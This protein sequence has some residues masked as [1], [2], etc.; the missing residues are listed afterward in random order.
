MYLP[1]IWATFEGWGDVSHMPVPVVLLGENTFLNTPRTPSPWWVRTKGFVDDNATTPLMSHSFA[2]KLNLILEPL[3]D[4]MKG[5][6]IKLGTRPGFGWNQLSN[7]PHRAQYHG[8]GKAAVKVDFS[9]DPT[10]LRCAV[11]TFVIF[12]DNILPRGSSVGFV[13][14]GAFTRQSPAWVK[15]ALMNDEISQSF[16]KRL[17]APSHCELPRTC[18]R[19][20]SSAAEVPERRR[21]PARDL[22][23]P[24]KHVLGG[25]SATP[26]ESGHTRSAEQPT[27]SPDA[28]RDRMRDEDCWLT[29]FA[30]A[31][32]NFEW[33]VCPQGLASSPAVAQRLF[34]NVPQSLPRVNERNLPTRDSVKTRRVFRENITDPTSEIVG[35]RIAVSFT[36]GQFVTRRGR[37]APTEVLACI[38]GKFDYNLISMDWICEHGVAAWFSEHCPPAPAKY[39]EDIRFPN[40]EP[41]FGEKLELNGAVTLMVSIAGYAPRGVTFFVF[42]D[43]CHHTERMIINRREFYDYDALHEDYKREEL[44]PG[45][46]TK[47]LRWPDELMPTARASSILALARI[48]KAVDKAAHVAAPCG[49]ADEGDNP[50][51]PWYQRRDGPAIRQD[52]PTGSPEGGIRARIDLD[53]DSGNAPRSTS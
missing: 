6:I 38:S 40:E 34:N 16:C 22:A 8:I 35:D 53:L 7:Q 18:N 15:D 14:S 42:D 29:G 41:F 30:T 43:T 50:P 33:R 10:S 4:T 45:T 49:P 52:D 13:L 24:T 26:P 25:G 12:E 17:S 48:M 2:R 11:V 19:P 44:V 28:L 9:T 39:L 37:V 36:P 5:P 47:E 3:E 23:M 46:A 27:A 32:G 31:F 21:I 51:P 1:R 20:T